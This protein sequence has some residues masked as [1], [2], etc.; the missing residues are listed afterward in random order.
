[1]TVLDE[2][3]LAT[4]APEFQPVARLVLAEAAEALEKEGYGLILTDARRT[5]VRQNELYAQGRTAPGKIVTNA[6]GGQSP[7][8]FGLAFDFAPVKD[9]KIDWDA[10]RRIWEV[11]GKIAENYGLQWGGNF[12]SIVD[13]PHV[14]AMDWKLAQAAWKAGALEVA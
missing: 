14:E 2:K 8:N 6:K 7:H 4:L 12:K 13:L 3:K 10:P 9:G 5:I 1:M 11:V